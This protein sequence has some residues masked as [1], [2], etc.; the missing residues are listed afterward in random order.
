[1]RI[2]AFPTRASA[3]L[4]FTLLALLGSASGQ[5][6]LPPGDTPPPTAF[7]R[8]DAVGPS[9][10]HDDAD[11]VIVYQEAV[12]DMAPSGVTVV[13]GYA[14]TK[15]LT[16]AG[17]RDRAVL[18][19]HYDPQSSFVQVREVNVIRD[20]VRIPVDVSAV[21]DLPAPQSAIYWN[22]RVMMLQLPRLQVGDG[23]EVRTYRKG[24]TY[25]LL[26]EAVP[27]DE[28]YIP[29][30]PGEYF[31]MPRSTTARCIRVSPMTTRPSPTPGGASTCRPASTRPGS[32]PPATS[33]PRWSCRPPRAGR[34]RA[35][36]SST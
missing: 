9:A 10:D 12:N 35:A 33:C 32:L 2:H 30:M 11:Y 31:D 21:I 26:D 16:P 22:D 5:T 4:V 8:L 27:D 13:D 29:P 36:G 3:V 17:C 25:A 24:F 23:V 15:I 34:P 18:R 6:D 14:L 20:D 28:R 1:M 19:W 7:S